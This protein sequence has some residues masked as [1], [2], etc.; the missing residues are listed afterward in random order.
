M[1]KLYSFA[2]RGLR[3]ELFKAEKVGEVFGRSEKTCQRCGAR[4]ELV[5]SF[6]DDETGEVVHTFECLCG[7]RVWDD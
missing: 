2:G 5:R 4:L 3:M 7:A 1:F 6:V